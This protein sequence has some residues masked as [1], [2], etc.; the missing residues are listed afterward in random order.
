M[1][2]LTRCGF[3]AAGLS[4]PVALVSGHSD[5]AKSVAATYGIDPKNIYDYQNYDKLA[6]NPA[7]DVIYIILP[8]SMHEEFTVRGLK[9]GKHVLWEKPMAA[10]VAEYVLNGK[11]RLTPGEEV[12]ADMR[13]LAAIIAAARTGCV[14]AMK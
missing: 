12:L 7:V 8:N 1:A 3:L 10:S 5:K 6:D 13:V 14:T 2:D 9:A 4:R 11:D